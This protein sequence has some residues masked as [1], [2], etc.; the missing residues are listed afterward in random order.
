MADLLTPETVATRASELAAGTDRA[1]AADELIALVGR[2]RAVLEAARD[3][4]A[5]R[6]HHHTGDWA[7]TRALTLLNRALSAY[8][9]TDPF[10]WKVRWAHGRKP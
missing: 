4:V 8:G 10:D 9:W 7:A 3:H 1:G 5:A 6:L 2:D